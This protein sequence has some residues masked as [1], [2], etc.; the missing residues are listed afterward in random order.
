MLGHWGGGKL[1]TSRR[2]NLPH[3]LLHLLQSQDIP[4]GVKEIVVNQVVAVPH[5]EGPYITDTG[6]GP[7]LRVELTHGDVLEG[8]EER[9]D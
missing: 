2:V 1:E 6:I 8:W 4:R 5:L 3:S 7:Q 9:V